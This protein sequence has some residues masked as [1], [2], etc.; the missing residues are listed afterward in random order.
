MHNEYLLISTFFR[1]IW[2]KNQP[3]N[4]SSFCGFQN[5]QAGVQDKAQARILVNWFII[6]QLQPRHMVG[7][8]ELPIPMI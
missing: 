6:F 4:I 2:Y 5:G 7:R 1:N 8:L 3:T